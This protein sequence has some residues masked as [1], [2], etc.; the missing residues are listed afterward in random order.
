MEFGPTLS[1]KEYPFPDK[2]ANTIMSQSLKS[3]VLARIYGRGRGWAFS[4]MD[5]GAEFSPE[6]AQR[7]LSRLAA[8]GVIRRVMR[9]VYDYP[10]KGLSAGTY[11]SPDLH[12][13]AQAL[14]RK[15]SWRIQPTGNAALN[16]LGLSNQVPGR[17]VYLSDGPARQ[18][19]IGKQTLDFR[20]APLKE[21][22]LKTKEGALL[23]QA[24]KALG[25]DRLDAEVMAKL[26]AYLKQQDCSRILQDT[27]AV[28]EWIH[29][30]IRKAC[31]Q[32]GG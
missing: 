8:S 26:S 5:F 4:K 30:I 18:Y 14:A 19:T 27:K 25:K 16:L 31:E 10:P 22:A 2:P 11:R 15:F 20:K 24:I 29:N 21:A 6:G 12:Q 17:W 28:P 13:V 3:K 7:A 9:G 23:V 32:S 1:E